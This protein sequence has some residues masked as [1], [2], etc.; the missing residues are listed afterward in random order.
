MSAM[1]PRTVRRYALAIATAKIGTGLFFLINTWLLIDI[2]GRTSSAA[3]SLV[4]T[5][6]PGILVSPF[7][8][9][10]VDRG[11]PARLAAAA[12]VLRWIVLVA[13]AIA[14][15]AGWATAALG[16]G[17]SFWIALGNELQVIAWR[18]AIARGASAA[19][20]FRLNALTFVGGQTGQ[21]LG[22]A[23]SGFALAAWGATN[24]VL[25]ASAAFL[26]SAIFGYLVARR[27]GDADR[28]GASARARSLRS[29]ASE[30]RGGIEHVV[31]RPQIAFFH[32]LIAVNLTV[33]FGINGL[34]APF[35]REE[36]GLGPEAFGK[37]DAGYAFGAIG[38]GLVIV[39]WSRRFGKRAVLMGSFVLASA[40]LWA[41]AHATGMRLSLA[42]YAGLGLSF[43]AN[44]ISLSAAQ[45]ATA[46]AF[47]GRVSASFSLLCGLV[48][49]LLYGLIAACAAHH[50]LR[51]FYMAQAGTMAGVFVLVAV[52]TRRREI[53]RL[54]RTA[55]GAA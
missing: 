2:T 45:Q 44:V 19:Q 43:Q 3:I 52:S 15:R 13:Y 32:A 25:L 11:R 33:I 10:L 1:T 35:V 50:W 40:S 9:V 16:Y 20:L 14:Y 28:S 27:L 18:A 17:V 5:V 24:T 36:L 48:G 31:Q 22:A 8:G 12:E 54:L 51:Q 47:Q 30:L 38:G 37:I 41:F 21:I 55:P 42:A 53:R 49:L 46:P 39:R 23:A 4:M 7:L 26:A 34:L 6:L 29:Y